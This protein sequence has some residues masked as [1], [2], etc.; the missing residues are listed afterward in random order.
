MYGGSAIAI[1]QPLTPETRIMFE[2]QLDSEFVATHR[3]RLADGGYEN[4]HS[5]TWPVRVSVRGQNTDSMGLLIDFNWLRQ[6]LDH[7]LDTLR[8]T[9][10]N[11]HPTLGPINPTAEHVARHIAEELRPALPLNV[12]LVR[13]TV[14][15]APGCWA[16][17]MPER[18][19]R[20]DSDQM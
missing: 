11:E 1:G 7:V 4:A 20:D 19:R 14:G 2:V 12:Q 10:L 16:S 17:Y 5:H 8:D 18:H 3:V 6:L 9:N 13:V 15:E